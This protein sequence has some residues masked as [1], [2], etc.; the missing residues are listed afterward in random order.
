MNI[1]SIVPGVGDTFYCQNCERHRNLVREFKRQGHTPLIVPMYLPL[2]FEV[3]DTLK[4]PIFFGAINVYLEEKYSFYNKIPNWI[5]HCLESRALLRWIS[6]KTGSTDPDGLEEMT[7]S[8]MRS[9]GGKHEH[10]LN[11]MLSWLQTD[12]KPNVVHLSNGLLIGIGVKIKQALSIP[13][14]VTLQDEDQWI[15]KMKQPYAQQ[16]WQLIKEGAEAIDLFTPVSQSYADF[17]CGRTGISKDKMA[18]VPIGLNLHEYRRRVPAKNPMSIG[19]L[20]RMT[21]SLGLDILVDAFLILK[22]D[23][24][25]KNLKLK[26]HGGITPA[27]K[28]FVQKIKE[29][30]HQ[31]GYSSDVDIN[32]EFDHQHVSTFFDSLTVVSVPALKGEAFGLFIIESLASGIPVVQPNLGGYTEIIKKTGGGVLYDQNTAQGLAHALKGVLTALPL[33]DEISQRGREQVEKYY[34]IEHMANKL[35]DMYLNVV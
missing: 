28:K 30:I 11:R 14:F 10:E 19:Y 7:L 20:S 9:D 34:T 4:S 22:K 17:V 1:V 8:I 18:V 26:I 6:K 16:A 33:L 31:K 23:N 12:V 29:K 24:R 21:E 25:L 5:K 35:L 13:V 3:S 32:T 15:D 27:D 2:S